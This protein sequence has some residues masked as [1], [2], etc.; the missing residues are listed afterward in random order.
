MQLFWTH[1]GVFILWLYSSVC[2]CNGVIWYF[3]N[4]QLVP[5]VWSD[6]AVSTVCV[7]GMS[8]HMYKWS[9]LKKF[10]TVLQS[11]SANQNGEMRLSV[12]TDMVAI[13]THFKDLYNPSWRELICWWFCHYLFLLFLIDFKL[14]VPPVLNVWAFLALSIYLTTSSQQLHSSLTHLV[15]ESHFSTPDFMDR[16]LF[17][18]KICLPWTTVLKINSAG[19]FYS[20]CE[21]DTSRVSFAFVFILFGGTALMT[22]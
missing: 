19:R 18:T 6:V 9:G 13:N 15:F 11:L 8:R 16:I 3:R 20:I 14:V 22:L 21:A 10:N 2:E 1:F 17:H 7:P 5:V 12:E 4:G